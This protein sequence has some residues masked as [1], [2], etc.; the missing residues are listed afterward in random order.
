[1]PIPSPRCYYCMAELA[2]ENAPCP[3]CGAQNDRVENRGDQLR[4]GM[5]LE[6]DK[7]L[8]GRAL[9]Q[10]GFGIT[11]I[12]FDTLLSEKVAIK[13]FYPQGF[14]SRDP[15]RSTVLLLTGPQGD[16][17]RGGM[18]K[19]MNEARTLARFRNIPNIV[20]VRECFAENGT[21]YIV[22]DYVQGVT[23]KKLAAE[24][25]GKLPAEEV[26]YYIL[27][28]TNALTAVHAAG[29]LHRDIAPDNIIVKPDGVAVLLDFGAARQISAMGEHSNTIN[30]KHGFAPEEQYRTRGE[31]G[32][33]TDVYAL[34]A[35]VYRLTTRVT[36]L[37]A[38]DRLVLDEPL[39]PPSAYGADLS[40]AA[41]AA[42]LHGL[43]VRGKDRPQT[44]A[45]FRAELTAAAPVFSPTP[46]PAPSLSPSP[47]PAPRTAGQARADQLEAERRAAKEREA[48]W[49]S[50]QQSAARQ[51]NSWQP[52]VQQPPYPRADARQPNVSQQPAA[53]QGAQGGK[54]RS[55]LW[56]ALVI[57]GSAV[58]GLVLLVLMIVFLAPEEGTS[59]P[60]AAA[61]PAAT[62]APT[63][64]A[65]T[66]AEAGK[67][68][69][70]ETNDDGAVTL[71]K[72][73]GSETDVLVP[74][75]VDGVVVTGIKERCFYKCSA[76]TSVVIPNGVT[77]IGGSAFYGCT[78]L[79]SV[80]IPDGVT[81][82]GD[83]AFS[84]CSSL[85]S[86][87]I[88]NSIAN[89]HDR[90]FSRCSSL[91]SVVIPS[92]VTGIGD[93]AFSYCTSLTSVVIPDGVTSIGDSAFGGCWALTSVVIP[94]GV[95]G[96][97]ESA[98]S[99]CSSLTSVVIPDGVTSIGHS[100]FSGC[101]SLTSVVI[102]DGVTSIGESIFSNCSSL[103][104]IVIPDGV[105]SI[106]HSTFSG[107]SSLTSVVIPDSV[108]S[109]GDAQ[110]YDQ[111]F[112]NCPRLTVTCPAGSY[113]ESY[114][115]GLG[116]RYTL[117]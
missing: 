114:C 52:S 116:I 65:Y 15:E 86:V 92:G 58:L 98:F 34:A 81:S 1:M 108:A 85:T 12:G 9:G 19:F 69:E 97:S 74:D 55:L 84:N 79:I 95:T 47:A 73:I 59:A 25:G 78:S 20:G 83:G 11:Y 40:P 94:D 21:A 93:G 49:L 3:V 17:F 91:I 33:W 22:M 10:G 64:R 96:I 90:A 39:A 30:V 2:A 45:Q 100:A 46:A 41:E 105:T 99:N 37:P 43:A 5:R 82:I 28:L 44:V 14:V 57:A 109:I 107:C 106:G 113:A 24:R 23:L 56:K 104:S 8:V 63:P 67:L 102:P 6:G 112:Y 103:T 29:L 35:T 61:T 115:R 62:P 71:T 7:Y 80:I 38:M 101:S 31:Q 4:C 72:Y 42:V 75:N 60:V 87:I 111:P 117:A 68:Y 77:S 89:I 54:R 16:V 88:P 76:V 53:R 27:P 50:A 32:P 13:E 36:P 66:A 18:E 26:L 48:R 51:P 110:W 70:Y